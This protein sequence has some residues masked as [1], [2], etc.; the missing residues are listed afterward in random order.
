MGSLPL[1]RMA[2]E[3]SWGLKDHH[4]EAV[5]VKNAKKSAMAM[6]PIERIE[7]IRKS[8]FESG[9]MSLHDRLA[10]RLHR[11][12]KVLRRIPSPG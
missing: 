2:R 5:S 10:N 8:L 1:S 7:G 4:S 3:K 6:L 11:C 12:S 9:Q